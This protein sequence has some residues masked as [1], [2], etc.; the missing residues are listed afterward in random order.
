MP[1]C[2]DHPEQQY[3]PYVLITPC[4]AIQTLCPYCVDLVNHTLAHSSETGSVN[5][6]G[7][8]E[9]KVQREHSV[10]ATLVK[11]GCLN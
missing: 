4:G 6:H 2:P 7:D 11:V 3:E 9:C 1:Q 5:C 10:A 8:A